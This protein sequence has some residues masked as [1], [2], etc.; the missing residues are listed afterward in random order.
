M[1]EGRRWFFVGYVI[2]GS[3]QPCTVGTLLA[4][5]LFVQVI[6]GSGQPCMVGA[7]CSGLAQEKSSPSS[8][9]QFYWEIRKREEVFHTRETL[10]RKPQYYIFSGI[11]SDSCH[12]NKSSG[13]ETGRTVIGCFFCLPQNFFTGSFNQ[14]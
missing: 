8:L 7:P 14:L 13:H 4:I 1:E 5:F 11:K 10:W 6:L 9:F 3:G 12:Q 2:L